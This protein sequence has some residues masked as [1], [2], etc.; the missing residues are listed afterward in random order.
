MNCKKYKT[1]MSDAATEGLSARQRSEF[2]VH[3]RDCSGCREELARAQ[4]LVELIDRG[5]MAQ[6]S[7]EPSVEFLPRLRQRLSAKD[8]PGKAIWTW[9]APAVACAA[10]VVIALAIWMTWPGSVKPGQGAS[11]NPATKSFAAANHATPN[12]N[13]VGAEPLRASRAPVIAAVRRAVAHDRLRIERRPEVAP[14][15]I[16]PGE[17]KAVL[18]FAAALQSGKIDGAKLLSE[19]RETD[20]PIEIKPI[21]IPLLDNTAQ[22]QDKRSAPDGQGTRRD[23]A[24]GELAQG[25]LP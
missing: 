21:V 11:T 23:F 16:P 1:W 9:R 17:G 5:V 24:G 20:Q 13:S 6:A 14:V 3:I 7:V 10:V 18:Q 19:Q 2:D 4:A 25:L 12:T 8:A 15:I 22:T